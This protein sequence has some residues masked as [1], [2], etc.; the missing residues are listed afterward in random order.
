MY[1]LGCAYYFIILVSDNPL[2][3]WM[4]VIV[5]VYETSFPFSVQCEN[6]NV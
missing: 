6:H 2:S 4:F 5:V 3:S 1:Q